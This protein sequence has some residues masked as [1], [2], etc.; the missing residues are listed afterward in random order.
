M[1][2]NNRAPPSPCKCDALTRG[3][4]SIHSK[5]DARGGGGGAQKAERV[6]IPPHTP[7]SASA[8]LGQEN[9]SARRGRDSSGT[10]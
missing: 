2:T 3:R 4:V 7:E 5:S 9:S 8:N 6:Q 1:C 10:E